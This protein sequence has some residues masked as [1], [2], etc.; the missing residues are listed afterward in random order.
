[1]G[2]TSTI[3]ELNKNKTKKEHNKVDVTLSAASDWAYACAQLRKIKKEQQPNQT[4]AEQTQ[5]RGRPDHSAV[6]LNVVQRA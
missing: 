2:N 3:I 6:L 1:M 4:D 5:S